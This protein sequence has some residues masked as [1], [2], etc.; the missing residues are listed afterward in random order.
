[1]SSITKK[2]FVAKL[3]QQQGNRD[4]ITGMRMK[5]PTLHHL[6]PSRYYS[7]NKN[8]FIMLDNITHRVINAMYSSPKGWRYHVKELSDM[9]ELMEIYK[10]EA[11][12]R[13]QAK[14][15]DIE[16]LDD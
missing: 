4:A 7:Y 1:M 16:V 12:A 13:E 2:K 5:N 10:V 8:R 3:I 15:E 9:F 11:I 14:T 6:D